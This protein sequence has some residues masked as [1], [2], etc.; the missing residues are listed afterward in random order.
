MK[1]LKIRTN[2]TA[3]QSGF[4]L[5]EVMIGI[6]IFAIGMLALA[7]LQGALTR[8]TVEAKVRTGAVNIA[9]E[10]IE[11]SRG[12]ERITFD[13]LDPVFAYNDIEDGVTTI[14]GSNGVNYTL[15]VDVTDYYYNL[16][17]DD[18]TVTVPTGALASDYKTVAITVS[19]GDSR[20]FV[21]EEGLET[22]AGNDI[23]S[24]SILLSANISGLSVA[25]T[26]RIAEELGGPLPG[27]PV[28]YTPGLNPD[29]V[30]LTLGDSKFK[31]SMTPEPEVFRDQLETRFDVIT[32][33]TAGSTH[34][35][36]REEFVA[37]SCECTLV[38]SDEGKSPAI[39][40][41]D[42]YTEPEFVTKVI[43]EPNSRVDQSPLC[44]IC[45]RDHH[46]VGGSS[47]GAYDP[48]LPTGQYD[49]GNHKHVDD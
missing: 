40:A 43:G 26:G 23:R 13:P 9:E 1:Y 44:D 15:T 45:C 28:N 17:G 34:F 29:I 38:G 5:M 2:Q 6:V 18:F 42:E 30:S 19:W 46:D 32:Y 10:F 21:V 36:R 11:L 7:S 24:G 48:S 37:E 4:S 33:S 14:A 27:P 49:G 35:L 20:K 8:S 12:F 3:H 25:A 39:W 16:L 41:G 47:G 31:E 22:S